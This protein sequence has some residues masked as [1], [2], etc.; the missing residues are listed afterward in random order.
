MTLCS[1]STNGL[2]MV[3]Y[4]KNHKLR[5]E[6]RITGVHHAKYPFLGNLKVE[7]SAESGMN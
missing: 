1:D 4:K 6:N 2:Q 5:E 7:A 3:N